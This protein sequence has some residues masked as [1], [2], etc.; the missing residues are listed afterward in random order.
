MLER[1]FNWCMLPE[2]EASPLTRGGSASRV[3]VCMRFLEPYALIW[4]MY[5]PSTSEML[6]W[7]FSAIKKMY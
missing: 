4:L 7:L 1:G 3:L 6:V 2:N 5:S